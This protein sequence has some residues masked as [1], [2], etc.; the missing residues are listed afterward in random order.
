[1]Q[2]IVRNPGKGKAVTQGL[3]YQAKEIQPIRT[4]E[5]RGTF[6]GITP[7]LPIMRR[8]Y[9]TFI[10]LSSVFFL[11]WYKIVTKTLSWYRLEYP[12]CYLQISW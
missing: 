4:Q 11:T 1:M 12:T 2:K 3:L 6:K 9:V 5:S 10:L 7:L 8:A